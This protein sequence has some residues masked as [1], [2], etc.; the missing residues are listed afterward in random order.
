[1]NTLL[2]KRIERQCKVNWDKFAS[3]QIDRKEYNR[4]S[5]ITMNAY[6]KLCFKD[7]WLTGEKK[8][9]K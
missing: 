8:W 2:F 9:E 3:G 4:R 5:Q 6:T 1:M 7:K